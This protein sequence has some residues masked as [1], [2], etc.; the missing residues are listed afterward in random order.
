[1]EILLALFCGLRKGEIQGLKF[2]DFDMR[3]QTVTIERQITSNPIIPKGQSKI[4]QYEIV[5]RA[6]KTENSFRTLRVPDVVMCEL[7]KR[8]YIVNNNKERLG[9]AYVDRDYI[10]CQDNG[11]PHAVTSINNALLK[12]C[13][14]NALPHVTVHSL[15]H[16]FASILLEKNTPLIKISALLGHASVHTTF[17][18]YCEVMDENEK[19]IDFMNSTFLPE[20][21]E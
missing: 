10:S 20:G 15:R 21:S 3:N 19:I 5:E 8:K 16:M 6:P 11:L 17:E 9:S 4:E 12:I 1:M 2:S 7:E 13:Y 18:Y 14:R